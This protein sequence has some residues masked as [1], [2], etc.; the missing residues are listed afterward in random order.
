MGLTYLC[1]LPSCSFSR[2]QRDS[3]CLTTKNTGLWTL[4]RTQSSCCTL[5]SSLPCFCLI[6]APCSKSRMQAI[7]TALHM[8]P[9]RL[10]ITDH[11]Q[12]ERWVWLRSPQGQFSIEPYL[13]Y[14]HVIVFA[15]CPNSTIQ[16]PK[17]ISS[18]E[19]LSSRKRS[20]KW[21][22]IVVRALPALLP[23]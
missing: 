17:K 16:I 11:F 18:S 7:D 1:K 2:F 8:G 14:G 9:K 13:W 4:P 5:S 10:F 23:S 20:G 15:P 22:V 12:Y 6:S 19:K 3:E 21:P